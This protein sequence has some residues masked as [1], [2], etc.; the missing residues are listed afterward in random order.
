MTER[1]SFKVVVAGPFAAGKSTLLRSISSSPVVGTEQPTSGAE[2]GV[3]AT[4]TVGVEYGTYVLAD[5]ELEVELRLFGVPGQER[6]AFMWDI[7]GE[8]MDGLVL[9]VD[10]TEVATWDDAAA[11]LAHFQDRWPG[12][13]V[14]G[15]TRAARPERLGA[16]AAALGIAPELLL[17]CDVRTRPGAAAVV[18]ELL[19]RVLDAT[20]RTAPA[21]AGRG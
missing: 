19:V 5:D 3:K 7:V 11:V 18:V 6:F 15:A 16:L 8:G 9:L 2:S 1:H 21:P 17:V 10:P 14:V 4:T 12:P 20:E 13:V